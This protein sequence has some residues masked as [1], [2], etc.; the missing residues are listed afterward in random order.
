MS[1]NPP[2]T[3]YWNYQFTD[4]NSNTY[5]LTFVTSSTPDG[6]SGTVYTFESGYGLINGIQVNIDQDPDNETFYGQ[7]NSNAY[8]NIPGNIVFDFNNSTFNFICNA[9]PDNQFSYFESTGY[10]GPLSITSFSGPSLTPPACYLR[11]TMILTTAG[12]VAVEDLRPG[13]MV[14]TRFGPL[15]P[16]KWIGEQH[17]EGRF[18]K[19]AKAPVCF[20]AGSLGPA[21]PARDLWVSSEHCMAI[22]DTLVSA[23]LLVNGLSITQA[24]TDQAVAY[25]HIDLGTHD[26]VIANGAWSESYAEQDNRRT[27]TNAAEFAAAHPDHGYAWQP[28]C[29]PRARANSPALMEIFEK[30]RKNLPAGAITAD[31][32]LHLMAD[33]VRIDARSIEG[34]SYA[35]VVPARTR[36]L[37]LMSN[38]ARPAHVGIN[39]DCRVLGFRTFSLT[40]LQGKRTTTLPIA[41]AMADGAERLETNATRSWRWTNGN[42]RLVVPAS[43]TPLTLIVEGVG[44]SRY[45][46]AP[47]CTPVRA[48][49]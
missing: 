34:N 25:Y 48:A 28:M 27:F 45:I 6:G 38:A 13:D 42:C 16:V 29:L 2:S 36:D 19:G 44:M 41:T 18:L 26:L 20:K 23:H 22:G 3:Y 17:L 12:E 24:D 33:G 40:T 39:T 7:L 37:R 47:T 32:D 10:N 5:D 49:A 1:S 43:A 30:Q 21:V 14:V 4:G 31:H 46:T 35:F 15:R 8:E 11:G 9:D